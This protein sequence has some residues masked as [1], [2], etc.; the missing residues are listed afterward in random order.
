MLLSF[1]SVL[2]AGIA[3]AQPPGAVL[4]APT[5]ITQTFANGDMRANSCHSIIASAVGGY[6]DFYVSGWS[7]SSTGKIVWRFMDPGSTSLSGLLFPNQ[8]E[9]AVNGRNIEVGTIYDSNTG[10]LY[11]QAAY[12]RNGVGFVLE[13]Y[14]WTGSGFSALPYTILSNSPFLLTDRNINMD[15]YGSTSWAVV[16]T[17]YTTAGTSILQC[18]IGEG[19]NATQVITLDGTE[20]A[21]NP[22]V[23]L[24][25]NSNMSPG[26][27][28]ME[29]HFVYANKY[30][31]PNATYGYYT[32]LTEAVMPFSV[33]SLNP[34]NYAPL[35]EDINNIGSQ[36]MYAFPVID[37]PD[38]CEFTP[39]AD[40]A[41]TYTTDGGV[42]MRYTNQSAGIPPTTKNMVDGSYGN[43]DITMP[44]GYYANWRP[45]I[46]YNNT[47]ES[48]YIGWL[49]NG[50]PFTATSRALVVE[51]SRDGNSLLSAGDYMLISSNPTAGDPQFSKNSFYSSFLYTTFL[52]NNINFRHMHHDW[53]NSI[54]FKSQPVAIKNNQ[55]L[56]IKVAQNPFRYAA[57]FLVSEALNDADIAAT[58]IDITG[59]VVYSGV[60]S[61]R[62]LQAKLQPCFLRLPGGIYI[63]RTENKALQYKQQQKLVKVQ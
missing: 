21:T 42:H 44:Y 29:V 54:S 20:D 51:V 52:E 30:A 23:A 6:G 50:Y 25:K 12:Y 26:S 58:M 28:A 46:A 11:I 31:D 40:W 48:I 22:D 14:E 3:E 43:T 16:W 53:T 59:K 63:L 10:I 8:G 60:C 13:R 32:E 2:A 45:T 34:S 62:Q 5:G 56:H 57:R 47:G 15:M 55:Q 18:M 36:E 49:F 27:D 38:I 33:Y 41:Y 9:I 39:F 37:C 4:P 7:N 1:C 35:R 24:S 61:G 17:E 19:L